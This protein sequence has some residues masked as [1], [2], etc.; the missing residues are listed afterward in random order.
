MDQPGSAQSVLGA[1]RASSGTRMAREWRG[2]GRVCAG[3]RPPTNLALAGQFGN[4]IV[5]GAPLRSLSVVPSA[6]RS[7]SGAQAARGHFW[8]AACAALQRTRGHRAQFAGVVVRG[9]ARP[10][11]RE[12]RPALLH[13]APRARGERRHAAQRGTPFG[14]PGAIIPMMAAGRPIQIATRVALSRLLPSC[15]GYSWL[16]GQAPWWFAPRLPVA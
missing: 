4:A 3:A 5:H 13:F 8:R 16:Y 10:V 6:W 1:R 2:S 7:R 15:H 12:R 9:A 11:C 14:R